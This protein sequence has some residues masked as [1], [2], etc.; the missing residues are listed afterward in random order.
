M[1]EAELREMLAR[2][3]ARIIG[4]A[5]PPAALVFP[6]PHASLTPLPGDRYRSKTERRYALTILDV[7]IASGILKRYW[8][9]PMKG[10]YLA[11]KTTYT[12]DFLVEYTDATQP[13]ECH[14]VK[15][16]FIY[17]KD[18]QK[19]KMAAA[20]YPCF[21]FIIAQWKDQ[22]WWFKDVPHV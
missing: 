22:R 14:E 9:E 5:L 11:P 2:G 19:T 8:Y 3:G 20:L 13:L 15:G 1:N 17:P 21:R 4:D 18:M 7:G 10:L 16:G 12:V 6:I